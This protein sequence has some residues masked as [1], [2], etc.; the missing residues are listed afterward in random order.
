MAV[1]W[2][3]LNYKDIIYHSPFAMGRAWEVVS[4]VSGVLW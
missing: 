1:K 2:V 4:V 3:E